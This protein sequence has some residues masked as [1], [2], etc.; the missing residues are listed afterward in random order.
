M[1]LEKG[2]LNAMHFPST[3]VRALTLSTS[4]KRE[5]IYLRSPSHIDITYAILHTRL[6]IF[7]NMDA[8]IYIKQFDCL[9][10]VRVT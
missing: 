6:Q 1:V 2:R 8:R 10:K 3:K 4:T 7:I 5:F 9:L